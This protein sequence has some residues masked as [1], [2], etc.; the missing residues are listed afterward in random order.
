MKWL[1]VSVETTNEA[2]EPVSNIL[3]EYDADG[4]S[5]E[6]PLELS[7]ERDSIYG[8]FYELNPDEYVTEG[9]MIRAY[10]PELKVTDKMLRN[11][12]SDI[13]ALQT[14]Q[15]DIGKAKV[16]TSEIDEASWATAWKKYY[17]PLR[18]TKYLT[19]VPNWEDY[20]V[21]SDEEQLIWMDP[22]MAFGT[23]THPTTKLTLQ[24]LENYVRKG[25]EVIDVGCGSGI[26]SIGAALLGAKQVRAFDLDH[27]AIKST[28]ENV[29][30]NE[31]EDKIIAKQNDLLHNVSGSADLIV[32]NIL[33]EIIVQFVADARNTLRV[34]GIFITSGIIKQKHELVRDTLLSNGFEIIEENE[35]D[36][37]VAIVAKRIK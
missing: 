35:Q 16:T 1:E 37:W 18:I 27:V 32:S 19:V 36:D 3:H 7:K 28:N 9:V 4:V 14:F 29:Q 2:I 31:L 21:E 11:L 25:D 15:I 8:E 26:L 34:N 20:V 30:L 17:K 13:Q 22:G 33:A 24:A 23:G 5:I 10:Y 12:T 6:D